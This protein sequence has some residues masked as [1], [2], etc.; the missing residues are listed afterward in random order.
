MPV[1]H[2]REVQ[3]QFNHLSSPL[4]LVSL[5]RE[6]DQVAWK[7]NSYKS[8]SIASPY[9]FF[10]ELEE[11]SLRKLCV[12]PEIKCFIRLCWKK[13]HYTR[14]MPQ[15][16][17]GKNIGG[18]VLCQQAPKRVDHLCFQLLFLLTHL[19]S[20]LHVTWNTSSSISFG[21]LCLD[22]QRRNFTKALQPVVLMVLSTMMTWAC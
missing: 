3:T 20:Y 9:Q 17:L 13:R 19:E 2:S 1:H 18:C 14:D 10:E 22:W 4:A 5:S 15:R 8:I 12:P 11:S 21:F 6:E 7:L 16:R